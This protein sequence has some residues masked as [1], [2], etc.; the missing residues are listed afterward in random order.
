MMISP[1]GLD[2]VGTAVRR[3]SNHYIV[4]SD[5]SEKRSSAYTRYLADVKYG[6]SQ[7]SYTPNVYF[8]AVVRPGGRQVHY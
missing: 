8:L 7:L 1:T 5:S 2:D 3:M 6:A 4:F